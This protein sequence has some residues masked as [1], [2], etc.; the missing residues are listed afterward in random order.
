MKRELTCI[1]CPIGCSL[2]AEL[3]DGKLI[4]VS[5]NTC[6]RGAEYAKNEC[7]SPVRRITTTVRCESG[8]L[9]PVKTETTIP[10]AKVF[11]AM[12][13]INNTHPRLPISAGDVIIEDV[14]GSR[15]VAVKNIG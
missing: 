5:G 3:D 6:S 13:I 9:L 15:I 1:V 2:V 4:N 8:E 11:Q 7:I 14:F 10:K 12:E